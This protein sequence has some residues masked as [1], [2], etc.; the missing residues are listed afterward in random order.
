MFRII[1]TIDQESVDGI[2]TKYVCSSHNDIK[3]LPRYGIRGT[4]TGCL[5]KENNPCA[6][7]SIAR[8]SNGSTTELYTLS[9]TNE[10]VK[11]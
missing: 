8:I 4:Q 7:G 2:F 10:W 9:T 6:Y 1:S 5:E 11:M 3:L